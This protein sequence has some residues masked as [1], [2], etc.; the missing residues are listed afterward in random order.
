MA[1]RRLANSGYAVTADG[2]RFL[3]VTTTEETGH[4]WLAVVINWTAELKR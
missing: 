4:S 3:F 1:L 2:L